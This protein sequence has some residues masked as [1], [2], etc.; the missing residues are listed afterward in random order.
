MEF[1]LELASFILK[2]AIIVI[3]LVIVMGA[4]AQQMQKHK[5]EAGALKIKDVTKAWRQ[6]I[7]AIQ[8][9]LLPDSK[10]KEAEKAIKKQRKQDK[11]SPKTELPRRIFVLKFQGSMDAKEVKQLTHEVNAIIAV[12]NDQ[13]QVLVRL[14]SGGGVVHGY[15]LG[16]AQLRRLRD[17]GMELIVSVDKVAASGGY[18]MACVANQIIAAPFAI[19]GSIGVIAQLPNF[20]RWLKKHD[21]DFEQLTA[22]EYKRTL[23][24]FGENTEQGRQKFKDDLESI[25][26]QF[27]AF[28]QQHRAEVDIDKVATGE[29]WTA[30]QAV[31]LHLVDAIETS[32]AWLQRRVTEQAVYEVE[33]KVKKGLGDRLGRQATLLLGHLRQFLTQRSAP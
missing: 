31:D 1:L 16:A 9:S 23:T 22:G 20:H 21:V 19:I 4:I 13:D 25:H 26:Q 11:K 10:R 3:A 6:Q 14:E 29:I 2:A 15:G 28:V 24:V 7:D 18:M 8:L 17:H 5:P 30:Q 27:K 32:D 12:A 33:Y